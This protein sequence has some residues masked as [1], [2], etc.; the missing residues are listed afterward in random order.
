MGRL[1]LIDP[2]YR[3]MLPARRCIEA[4]CTD[5]GLMYHAFWRSGQ[6]GDLVA[7]PADRADIRIQ[8]AS[9]DLVQLADGTLAFREAYTSNRIRIDASMTDLLR[10]RA[11]L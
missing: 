3:A 1:G 10:L 2:G 6:L 9:I 4:T 8:V 5:L 7:G 11:V